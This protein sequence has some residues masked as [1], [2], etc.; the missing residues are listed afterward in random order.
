MHAAV[1]LLRTGQPR[2]AGD[3]AKLGQ[4]IGQFSWV[5]VDPIGLKG[6]YK[7]TNALVCKQKIIIA[8]TKLI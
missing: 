2:S 8:A 4:F 1:C 7:S 5:T 3:A 6:S